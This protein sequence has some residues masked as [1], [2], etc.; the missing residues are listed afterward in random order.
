MKLLHNLSRWLEIQVWEPVAGSKPVWQRGLIR[1][2]RMLI[3]IGRDLFDGQLTLRAMSMVYTTL[4]SIVPLLAF[5]FSVLKGF[6]IHNL[7]EPWLMRF[8]QPLGPKGEELAQS[9]IGF[10]DNVKAGV[11][12]SLGL[13]LLLWTIFSL[14]QKVEAGFNYVWRVRTSRNIVSRMSGYISILLIGPVLMVSAISLTASVAS[15]TIVQQIMEIE[16]FGS[17]IVWAGKLIP[18]LMV[19]VAFTLCYL[20]IPNTR[21]K[22]SAALIGGLTAGILWETIGKLFASFVAASGKYTAIYS[23]FAV[24]LLFMFWLY[25][26]WLILLIGAQIAY[27]QQHPRMMMR[28]HLRIRLSSQANEQVALA[29]MHN[30][31]LNFTRGH[32]PWNDTNLATNMGIAEEA[33]SGIMDRLQDHGLLLTVE[34]NGRMPGRDIHKILLS[35]IL[36]AVRAPDS[37]MDHP[38][39]H[40]NLATGASETAQSAEAAM[41]ASLDNRT[42]A[43]LVQESNKNAG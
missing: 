31:A 16:P 39:T 23:G 35:D 6:G 8:F 30:I 14:I 40:L 29:V 22:P 3:S 25:I 18:Y 33:L 12:G 17:L 28:H 27:Y 1:A 36:K 2:A 43:S 11:L 21:V 37:H 20:F 42:L 34:D 19:V 26:S 5:S 13:L 10:V 41:Y 32:K 38:E 4:L 24:V 7:L 15:N 9:L